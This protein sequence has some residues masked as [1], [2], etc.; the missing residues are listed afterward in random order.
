MKKVTREFIALRQPRCDYTMMVIGGMDRSRI[1]EGEPDCLE[2]VQ[3]EILGRD[4]LLVCSGWLV[5]PY[6]SERD[7]TMIIPWWWNVQVNAQGQFRHYDVTPYADA[8]IE[9][10][11]IV[12][13]DITEYIRDPLNTLKSSIPDPLVYSRGIFYSY[14]PETEAQVALGDL[15]LASIFHNQRRSI[16]TLDVGGAADHQTVLGSAARPGSGN[17]IIQ[18]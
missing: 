8:N 1:Y 7:R 4:D 11:Y 5:G 9:F 3:R 16:I 13:R 6:N 12:D 18:I 2:N 10:E 15:S 14:D 17:V